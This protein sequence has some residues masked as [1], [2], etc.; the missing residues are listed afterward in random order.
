MGA[1]PAI[2]AQN[3]AAIRHWLLE[4]PLSEE[5]QK[6]LAQLHGEPYW[7]SLPRMYVEG[8][9]ALVAA[10]GV[11][12][13]DKKLASICFPALLLHGNPDRIVPS[14]EWRVLSE[15]IPAPHFLTF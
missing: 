13:T 1:Q 10:G 5:W 8:Q 11:I 15:P 9:E 4:A 14:G 6:E 12:I 7:R 3:T 2:N